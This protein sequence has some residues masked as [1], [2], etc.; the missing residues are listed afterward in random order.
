ML[1]TRKNLFAIIFPLIIQQTL[2]VTIGMIDSMM[3][4][5]AGE[6]AVS[7]VSLVNTLDLLLI[8]AFS[9]LVTGGSI[10]VSQL[11][12]KKDMAMVRSSAKQLLYVATIV[13]TL[14]SAIVILLRFPLLSLLLLQHQPQF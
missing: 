13:A 1:F 11:F 8:Y 4:S 7:G 10:V 12:G 6:A 3:V 14:V 9:S 2:N 5:S